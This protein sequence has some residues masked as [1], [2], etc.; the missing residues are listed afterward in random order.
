[1]DWKKIVVEIDGKRFGLVP[2]DP[3]DNKTPIESLQF[4][5]RTEIALGRAGIKHL[6]ECLNM[7]EADLLR[8]PGVGRKAINEIREA[9]AVYNLRIGQFKQS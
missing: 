7:T 1:M 6:E 8:F 9:L 5:A 4:S 2:I 3:I